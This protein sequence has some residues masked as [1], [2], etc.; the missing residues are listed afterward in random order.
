MISKKI[1]FP[2]AAVTVASFVACGDDSSSSAAASGNTAPASVPTFMDID[3]YECSATVNKCAKVYIEDKKDTMQC[4]GVNKWKSMVLGPVTECVNFT[5]ATDNAT[6]DPATENASPDP[7][8]VDPAVDPEQAAADSAI[9]ALQAQF[10]SVFQ[11]GSFTDISFTENCVE[12]NFTLQEWLDV[13]MTLD[14]SVPSVIYCAPLASDPAQTSDSA[15]LQAALEAMSDLYPPPEDSVATP[16]VEPAEPDAGE[17]ISCYKES[18]FMCAEGPASLGGCEEEEGEVV[19]DQC[20]AGGELCD[21][22]ENEIVLH[23]YEGYGLTCA[24]LK[25]FMSM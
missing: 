11:Q 10:D 7:A 15:A 2:L 20:P 21:I 5:P 13:M 19:V 14:N 24:E 4:D 22:G 1:L 6:Q 16:I 12:N 9:N 23:L 8:T 25:A 17:R 18:D 3:N